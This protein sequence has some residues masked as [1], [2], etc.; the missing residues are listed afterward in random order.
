[1]SK[2]SKNPYED[3]DYYASARDGERSHRDKERNNTQERNNNNRNQNNRNRNNGNNNQKNNNRGGN[4]TMSEVKEKYRKKYG[5]VP[6][7]NAD[8]YAFAGST[9][10]EYK[11]QYKKKEKISKKECKKYYFK[12][13]MQCFPA[14][15]DWCLRH[16]YKNNDAIARMRDD[17]YMKIVDEDFIA[18]LTKKVKAG[19]TY[20]NLEFFPMI[21]REVL[22]TSATL[23]K[24]A[25]EKDPKAEV[26]ELDDMYA[27]SKLIMDKRMKRLMKAGISED[28][29]FNALSVIPNDAAFQYSPNYRIN[30]F[31][32]SLYEC[33]K[34]TDVPFAKLME[35]MF[36]EKRFTSFIVFALLERKEKFGTLTDNQ[37]KLYLDITNW[38]FSYLETSSRS[39]IEYIL[40]AYVKGR[41]NDDARGKDCNRRYALSSLS[42]QT[43][44]HIVAVL[45]NMMMNDSSVSKYL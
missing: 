5:D 28:L 33:A 40:T 39:D 25:L 16:G 22:I 30:Q 6:G 2:K 24:Q 29:A 9:F 7:A 17:I 3:Y 45:K 23:N 19:E 43:Y 36:D 32:N 15:V 34:G 27:L 21:I 8:V 20:R 38:V 1:M 12:A 42:E 18:R 10:K 41:K 26:F 11:K 37:K 31:Y 35:V 13:L 4:G 14:A 44:P